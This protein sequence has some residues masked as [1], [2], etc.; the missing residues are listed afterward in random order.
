MGLGRVSH[1]TTEA[2]GV[3]RLRDMDPQRRTP[4][5][6]TAPPEI[7]EW[8]TKTDLLE[9]EFFSDVE[10]PDGAQLVHAN[11]LLDWYSLMMRVGGD[12]L[13]RRLADGLVMGRN[14]WDAAT[15]IVS[16]FL[17]ETGRPD[18]GEN[19][20]FVGGAGPV[21]HLGNA[22]LEVTRPRG[23]SRSETIGTLTGSIPALGP[24]TR[25]KDFG[26]TLDDIA[27]LLATKGPSVP[28]ASRQ[29]RV[30]SWW[31]HRRG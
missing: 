4:P 19:G 23:C 7:A 1:H 2:V 22:R 8:I 17:Y 14:S 20:Q 16:P 31:K 25:R 21:V 27:E 12:T 6:A 30:W 24:R 9:V 10:T 28:Q 5:P 15:G 29:R 13:R 11:W 18:F 3:A 26:L